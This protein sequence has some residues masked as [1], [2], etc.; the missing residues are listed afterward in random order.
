MKSASI[1]VL[2]LVLA[3]V[4]ALPACKKASE[5]AAEK[6]RP[7]Y[8]M[9]PGMTCEE[10]SETAVQMYG[11][12]HTF[13]EANKISQ[14]EGQTASSIRSSCES[15]NTR[16]FYVL[17]PD[18][19]AISIGYFAKNNRLFSLRL[20]LAQFR[21]G[22]SDSDSDGVQVAKTSVEWVVG[23]R[24]F[25]G[26]LQSE[27]REK[28]SPGPRGT[29]K[30]EQGEAVE[31]WT[32]DTAEMIKSNVVPVWQRLH[33]Q[34][35]DSLGRPMAQVR[36]GGTDTRVSS[37]W[38]VGEHLFWEGRDPMSDLGTTDLW[39]P[40]IQGASVPDVLSELKGSPDKESLIQ[41]LRKE[42]LQVDP[43]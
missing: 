40:L 23:G 21:G 7:V 4:P 17:S 34:I 14:P 29:Q 27:R 15:G 10:F 26:V 6:S 37:V 43:R 24:P 28:C 33:Q 36:C 39:P 30:C 3:I 31:S 42:G 25:Q 38:R 9:Y 16:P 1:T 41:T 12:L 35:V 32:Q 22:T 18:E 11:K 8:G 19:S 20:H 2:L 13:F 5:K